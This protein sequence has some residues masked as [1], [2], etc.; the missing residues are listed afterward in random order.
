MSHLTGAYLQLLNNKQIDK[1]YR[2]CLD[3]LIS[4]IITNNPQNIEAILLYGGIVRDSRI[5]DDWSDIDVIVI[6]R[7]ITKR[8]A[9]ELA[10]IIERLETK[11]SIRIDLTQISL[12]EIVD[13]VL[14]KCFFN[15]EIINALSMREGVSIVVFGR[16]PNVNFTLEQE[17][18]AALFYITNT[19]S[20]LRRYIIEVLYRGKVEDHIKADLKRI[21]R[22]LFS[23]IRAS[24]R[25]FNIYTHP[26]EYSIP[27]LKR[28]FP[29]LDISFLIQLIHLRKNINRYNNT[30]ELIQIV[31]KIEK[32]T[33]EYVALCLRRYI[34]GVERNKQRLD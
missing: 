30:S 18:Q 6:F 22:W 25:L 3:E 31:Q 23:I 13:S 4:N 33:E 20:L 32:F 1:R 17:R 9:F 15:S 8:N 2:D 5:F 10:K 16:V 14:A 11:Y 7:D 27:Y 28:I 29:E 24:L 34:D 26:Y 21:V 19:L 12:K